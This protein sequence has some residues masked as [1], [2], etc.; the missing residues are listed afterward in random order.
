[1][2]ISVRA[3]HHHR[4]AVVDHRDPTPSTS[5]TALPVGRSAPQVDPAVPTN[6]SG[7]GAADV[8]GHPVDGR[9]AGIGR[10][11]AR[12]LDGGDASLAG[13]L[14][15][16]RHAGLAVLPRHQP[17]LDRE[18]ADTGEDVAAVLAVGHHG[19]VHRHLQEEVID[20]D[21][22]PIRALTTATFE[23]S[24]S[25]PPM[26]SIWRG[27]GVP[28][29]AHQEGVAILRQCVEEI[30]PLRGPAA[31]PHDPNPSAI[32]APRMPAHVRG[33]HRCDAAQTSVSDIRSPSR[34]A[35]R[36]CR[37]CRD[38]SSP[39]ARRWR[40]ASSA[41]RARAFSS[42]S[43][44]LFPLDHADPVIVGQTTSPGSTAAPAQTTGTLTEPSVSLTVPCAEIALDQT[45]KPISRGPH[46]AH[47]RVDD[48]PAQPARL[49]RG[50][51]KSPK[52]PASE[53]E[54][55]ASTRTSPG[56]ICSMATCTIQL[57]QGG[58]RIVTADPPIARPV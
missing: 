2:P 38:P 51:Q 28:M 50:G 12:G 26:P 22:R 15:V 33:V 8:P 52:Y 18:G 1:M 14:H 39:A 19:A 21:P 25:A 36:A 54:V 43:V 9:I 45:G 20:I 30:A 6:S 16:D 4:H 40:L 34:P 42:T 48:Q 17:A 44:G 49:R 35:V 55:G 24:G 10:D 29:I 7:I 56:L 23:V 37:T 41:S 3:Q 57:S 13:I 5:S 58:A 46:I 47:A 53:G 27:S 31:H 11:A 32:G